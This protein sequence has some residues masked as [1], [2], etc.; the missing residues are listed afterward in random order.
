YPPA[1]GLSCM[2][3]GLA[4]LAGPLPSGLSPVA[5][6][7]GLAFALC[8]LATLRSAA[9]DRF[10]VGGVLLVGGAV[11]MLSRQVSRWLS[12]LAVLAMLVFNAVISHEVTE[13]DD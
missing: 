9:D 10:L 11:L 6:S 7:M 2:V 3:V 1:M 5:L 8:G 13:G 12:P 4:I